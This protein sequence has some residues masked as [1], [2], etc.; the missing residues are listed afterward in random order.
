MGFFI[1]SAQYVQAGA[2]DIPLSA[3][4]KKAKEILI[5]AEKK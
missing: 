2:W 4:D 5:V 3:T 1:K